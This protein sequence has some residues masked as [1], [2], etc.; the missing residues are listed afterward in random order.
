MTYGNK[1]RIVITNRPAQCIAITNAPPQEIGIQSNMQIVI[2]GEVYNGSYAVTP[3]TEAQVLPTKDRIMVEDVT[4][5][6]I[7]YYETGNTQGGNTAY[8]GSEI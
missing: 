3:R 8:I 7:P 4:V 1:Q 2:G 6:A 5:K